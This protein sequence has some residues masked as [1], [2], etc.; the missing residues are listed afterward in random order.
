M[1]LI[2][3]AFSALPNKLTSIHTHNY[4]APFSRS[5][6]WSPLFTMQ[7]IMFHY[8]CTH[9]HW[10]YEN[11][12]TFLPCLCCGMLSYKLLLIKISEPRQLYLNLFFFWTCCWLQEFSMSL[13]SELPCLRWNHFLCGLGFPSLALMAI[14]MSLGKRSWSTKACKMVVMRRIVTMI[15]AVRESMTARACVTTFVTSFEYLMVVMAAL[16]IGKVYAHHAKENL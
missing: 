14:A 3:S 1:D 5:Q 15:V 4:P 6:Y 2:F 9:V 12:E 11:F 10:N 16:V 8:I 13:E 7:Y